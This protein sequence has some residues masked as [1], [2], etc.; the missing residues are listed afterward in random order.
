MGVVYKARQ[1]G[2]NRLV[3]LKM[4]RMGAH[5]SQEE[6][7]RFI[8]EARVVARLQHPNIIQ[9]YE[10]SFQ[11]EVPFFSMELVEG[12]NLAEWLAGK[13]QPFR[14]AGHLALA[15]AR[16]VHYAHQNGIVHRDLK[17]ANILLA[18]ALATPA[19]AQGWNAELWPTSSD[20]CPWTPKISDFGLA[21]QLGQGANQTQ[22]GTVMGTPSYMAPEQAEGKSREVGPPADVYALGA[23]L[24][25]MLT[26]RPPFNAESPMETV[27]LLFQAEPVPPS[28]LQPRVPRD[29]ETICLKCLKKEPHKRYASAH[30]LALDLQCFLSGEPIAARPTSLAEQ[31]WKWTRRRPALA[32]LLAGCLLALA[33]LVGLALWHQIDLGVK[34]DQARADHVAAREHERLAD[35]RNEVK[36]LLHEGEAALGQQDWQKARL[37]LDRARDKAGDEADLA[38]LRAR[39]GQLLEQV[40]HQR[41]DRERLGKFQR[42]RN[43][44]LFNATL[45]TGGDVVVALEDTRAAARDALALFGVTPESDTPPTTDSPYLQ[46]QEKTE[47]LADCYELLLVLAEAV[48]Q[49]LPGQSDDDRRRQAREALRLLDR[50]ARLGPSTQAYHLRRARYLAQAGETLEAHREQQRADALQPVSALDY[51]LLGDAAYRKGEWK[52]AGESFE[53]VLQLQPEHFWAQYYLALCRLKTRRPDLAAS[54]LTACLALRPDFPWPYLLRGAARGELGQ[55]AG[56]D[57]DFEAVQKSPLDDSARYAL[58]VNRGVLRIRQGRPVDAVADLQKAV[59][60]KPGQYQGYVNL[61]QAYLKGQQL[62][63]AVLQM[64][65]AIRRESSVAA[66]YRTRARIHLLRQEPTSALADLNVAVRLEA[67]RPSATLAED[68]VERGRILLGQK[69]YQTAESACDAAL[70]LCPRH[71]RAHRLRAEALLEQD[72]LPEAL[73]ALDSCLKFG[74][75]EADVFRA[76]AAIRAKLGEYPGAQTDYTRALELESDAATYASRGWTYLVTR[77]WDL[78]QPD[79]EKALRLDPTQG[80]AYNGR[81]FARAMLGQYREAVADAEQALRLGPQTARNLYNAARTYAQAAAGTLGRSEGALRRRCE[82]RALE[83][84]RGALELHPAAQRTAF[85]RNTI[86]AD[87]ALNPL[88]QTPEYRGLAAQY[89]R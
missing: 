44:A 71:A 32:G 40:D 52:R 33:A 46:E 68:H 51:F 85:W 77:A 84:L 59:S 34:L 74:P 36:D 73:E 69:E 39:T 72:R 31:A 67:A 42:R 64:D 75:P 56:A 14:Q 48:A 50:A 8:E 26:G 49:P 24:Y 89:S 82:G 22:N 25:E 65:E 79:F 20:F 88:R 27:M 15:L 35:L 41:G 19:Q 5:A 13:P 66:L 43:D 11:Q 45:F 61:A 80:D 81:G 83:L 28:R 78:A 4:V 55:L 86:Q 3:A 2:L 62:E 47:V 54:G 38:D 1:K 30:E 58:Y 21:K 29:L 87:P 10:I 9:I 6:L 37:E 63:D 53:S 18:P 16:A 76:R 12:G 57:A 23:I 17:P 7:A 60:L 70:A